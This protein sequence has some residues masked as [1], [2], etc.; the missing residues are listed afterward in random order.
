[1]A[2]NDAKPKADTA[3]PRDLND[4]RL[5]A[6]VGGGPSRSQCENDDGRG[7]GGGSGSKGGGRHTVNDITSYIDP[8]NVY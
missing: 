7:T 3:K 8:S 6:V 1:M 5:D 4:D 2:R